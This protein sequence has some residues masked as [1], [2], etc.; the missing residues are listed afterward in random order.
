MRKLSIVISAC[1]CW[2][3]APALAAE[4]RDIHEMFAPVTNLTGYRFLHG[5]VKVAS[6]IPQVRPMDVR[7]VIHARRGDLVVAAAEE[8]A[9]P[10]PLTDVLYQENPVVEIN[11]P[12]GTVK[13]SVAME[14]TCPPRQT[15]KYG[16]YEEMAGEYRAWQAQRL[17]FVARLHMPNPKALI[18]RF[19]AGIRGGASIALPSGEQ[20]VEMNS[21]GEIRIAENREWLRTNP[22]IRLDAMPE[23]I[24]LAID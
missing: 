22:L 21:R 14:A 9:L 10:F 18:I 5:A 24:Q 13:L 16:L 17:G 2:A 7:F 8:G 11:Q 20:R 23:A 15:F 19:P 3:C 12:K 6:T 1:I 4:Y